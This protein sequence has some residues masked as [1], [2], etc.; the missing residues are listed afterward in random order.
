MAAL[1]SVRK[2]LLARFLRQILLSHELPAMT[3][4]A[5]LDVK[6]ARTATRMRRF[7]TP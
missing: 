4:A 1:C 2:L 6:A 3:E 7:F 5:V